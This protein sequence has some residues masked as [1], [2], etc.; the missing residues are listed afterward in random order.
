M[1]GRCLPL[2]AIEVKEGGGKKN[3]GDQMKTKV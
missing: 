2:K 1:E 3:T